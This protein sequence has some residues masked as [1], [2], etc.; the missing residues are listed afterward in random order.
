MALPVAAVAAVLPGLMAAVA[1]PV[2][3]GAAAPP[4]PGLMATLPVA[5]GVMGRKRQQQQQQ[6]QQQLLVQREPCFLH[7]RLDVVHVDHV[8]EG[9]PGLSPSALGH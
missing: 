6:Q 7:Q 2:A 3:A 5:L 8:D 1:R 4:V 9:R